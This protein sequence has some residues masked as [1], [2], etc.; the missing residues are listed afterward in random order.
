MNK[1]T[2]NTVEVEKGGCCGCLILIFAAIGLLY[3]MGFMT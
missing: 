1:T 2:I 3:V